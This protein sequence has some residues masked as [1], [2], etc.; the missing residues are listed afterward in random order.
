[1]EQPAAVAGWARHRALSGPKALLDA[2]QRAPGRLLEGP[3]RGAASMRRM[4]D[5]G[6]F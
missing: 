2:A 6:V 3:G 1:M 4:R 5:P